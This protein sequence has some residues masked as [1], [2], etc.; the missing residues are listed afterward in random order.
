MVSGQPPNPRQFG[1]EFVDMEQAE[2]A[3]QA[4][5][6]R[7]LHDEQD[8]NNARSKDRT[9]RRWFRFLRRHEASTGIPERSP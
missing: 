1:H 3:T 9:R 5:A 2:I 7:P 6:A 4:E 8:R